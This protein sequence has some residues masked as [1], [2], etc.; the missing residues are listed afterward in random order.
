VEQLIDFEYLLA[1]IEFAI[2]L[3]IEANL[4]ADKKKVAYYY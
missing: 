4:V 3:V 2:N 1:V